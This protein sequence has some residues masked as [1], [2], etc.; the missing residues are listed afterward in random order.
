[1]KHLR[2][3]N[4][5]NQDDQVWGDINDIF[6]IARDEGLIVKFGHNRAVT[7]T[8]RVDPK[9]YL[10]KEAE[11][12]VS[13]RQFVKISQE[14]FDRLDALG[15]ISDDQKSGIFA[16]SKTDSND[17]LTYRYNTDLQWIRKIRPIRFQEREQLISRLYGRSKWSIDNVKT[18]SS[19]FHLNI[20][21]LRV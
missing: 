20:D 6:N 15:V 10:A 13:D 7:I 19:T 1:M 8:N 18:I 3:F 11:P 17:Y 16:V 4:E 2:R 5:S 21:N 12:I 14:M 9:G